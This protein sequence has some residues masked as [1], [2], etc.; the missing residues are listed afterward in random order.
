M[1]KLH[2]SLTIITLLILCM[3]SVWAAPVFLGMDT[4]AME[5]TETDTD[6]FEFDED[7]FLI[8]CGTDSMIHAT[9]FRIGGTH[10]SMRPASF[11]RVFPPPRPFYS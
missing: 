7:P 5:F 10:L 11:A 6:P 1:G 3:V 4:H 2:N 9:N 8:G